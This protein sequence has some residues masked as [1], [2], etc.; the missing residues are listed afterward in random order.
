MTV[1]GGFG[2]FKKWAALF[3]ALGLSRSE[4]FGWSS[5][6][7]AIHVKTGDSWSAGAGGVQQSSELIWRELLKGITRDELDLVIAL[8]QKQTTQKKFFDSCD[9]KA[10]I[11]AFEAVHAV[12]GAH[13][14]SRGGG[15]MSTS[16]DITKQR[17]A[18]MAH[19]ATLLKKSERNGS[20][21]FFITNKSGAK[22]KLVLFSKDVPLKIFYKKADGTGNDVTALASVP[23]DHPLHDILIKYQNDHA[24]QLP[25]ET[26]RPIVMPSIREGRDPCIKLHIEQTRL[27]DQAKKAANFSDTSCPLHLAR[28][29]IEVYK[30]SITA[31][32]GTVPYIVLDKAVLA[33][34]EAEAKAK[35]RREANTLVRGDRKQQLIA[36]YEKYNRERIGHVDTILDAFRNGHDELAQALFNKYNDVPVGWSV[37]DVETIDRKRKIRRT[38]LSGRDVKRGKG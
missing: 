22:S 9:K 37:D 2:K 11:E 16:F 35:A 12:D 32:Y 1:T 19:Q 5:H 28:W 25:N 33:Q 6:F 20:E 24:A 26:L 14:V 30:Y 34:A 4:K 23:T 27:F 8:A 17:D 31:A 7:S 36:F 15:H 29:A 13:A 38:M 3:R 18:A 10:T 21:S